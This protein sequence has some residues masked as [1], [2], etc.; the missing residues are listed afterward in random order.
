MVNINIYHKDWQEECTINNDTIF[1]KS[2]ENEKGK[3]Y[4]HICYLK[5]TWDDWG[6]DYFWLYGSEDGYPRWRNRSQNGRGGKGSIYVKSSGNSFQDDNNNYCGLGSDWISCDQSNFEFADS[7]PYTIVV[8][9]LRNDNI[10]SSYSSA[11]A[12]VWISGFGGEYGYN[13]SLGWGVA[14]TPFEDPALMSTDRSNCNIGYVGGNGNPNNSF[15]DPINVHP[16]NTN[17][18]YVSSMNGTSAAAPSVSGAIALI[19]EANPNLTWRDVK[20]ILAETGVKTDPN[21]SLNIQGDLPTSVNQFRWVNNAA[22]YDW[23]QWYGFG[24]IDTAATVSMAENYSTNLGTFKSYYTGWDVSSASLPQAGTITFNLSLDV[25]SAAGINT[26]E[27][28]RW[29]VEMDHT[30]VSSVGWVLVSPSNTEISILNPFHG[31]NVNPYCSYTSNGNCIWVPVTTGVAGFY[32]ENPNGTWQ[33]KL[34]DY[35]NDN[36]QG[37]INRIWVQVYGR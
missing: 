2:N 19:L 1:R 8:A 24:V 26:I 13:S 11:G 21:R 16:E 22:G 30:S 4:K 9:A 32:G 15:N 18:N 10:K 5:I 29:G 17:C 3:I 20:H 31:A 27:Y 14:G 6:D 37:T 36:V 35:A 7:I 28:I 12:G 34:S 23:H 33:F 25:A